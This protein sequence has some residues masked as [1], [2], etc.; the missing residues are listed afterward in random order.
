MLVLFAWFE[1][2]VKN[3]K[4]KLQKKNVVFNKKIQIC[5]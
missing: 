5:I 3:K 1:F 4:K 2:T